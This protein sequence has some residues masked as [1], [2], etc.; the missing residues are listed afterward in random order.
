MF[1]KSLSIPQ[2]WFRRKVVVSF[3]SNDSVA[4][5]FDDGPDPH[6]T[7]RVINILRKHRAR[8]TFFVLGK[9]AELYPRII[10][11]ILDSGNEIANHS[12]S[13]PSFALISPSQQI[14]EIRKC[15]SA[16]GNSEKKYFR[17]PFGH[18]SNKTPMWAS[19]LNYTTV[20]WSAD[21]GDWENLDADVIFER[22][23]TRVTPGSVVLLHDRLETATDVK[24]FR[25]DAMLSALDRFLE[26]ATLSFK[27][28]SEMFSSYEMV[29]SDW[30][31]NFPNSQ[32]HIRKQE[33]GN[34]ERNLY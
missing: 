33:F 30:D 10:Q 8:A 27:T 21:A 18:A 4:L 22:L 9:Q 29:E 34:L 17:P 24:F 28:L 32:K 26:N 20:C 12:Y 2:R 3:A 14:S 13:H 25:R 6:I 7:P 19:L 31:R 23:A 16:I 15:R 1:T 11:Q 5:T